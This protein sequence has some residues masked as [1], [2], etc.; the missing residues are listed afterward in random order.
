MTGI[1]LLGAR[2]RTE[3]CQITFFGLE[4]N[5]DY[6]VRR[7]GA[8]RDS[9]LATERLLEVGIRPRWQIFFLEPVIPDLP[10]LVEL[11]QELDLEKRVRALGH[12]F[13]VFLNTPSPDGEA[14]HLEHLRPAIDNL[15]AI[16]PYL[17]AKTCQHF[18]QATLQNCLG[19]AEGDLLRELEGCAQ[20]FADMPSTLAFMVADWT[21]TPTSGSHSPGGWQPAHRRPDGVGQPAD[22]N[23][24]R[25]AF[26]PAH[27]HLAQAY[28]R[29]T[30][31]GRSMEGRPDPALAAAV[32]PEHA[33]HAE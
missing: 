3:A 11:I 14:F 2:H 7:R 12:E 8:F 23:P 25:R 1:C 26:S 30:E 29:A 24:G 28:G 33:N 4:R 10:K 16:P 9:L 22:A 27:S 13:A 17:A 20:P 21:S 15:S 5:T 31:G 19:E 32:G 6:F 18:G